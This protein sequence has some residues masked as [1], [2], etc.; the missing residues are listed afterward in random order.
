MIPFHK[1]DKLPLQ[2]WPSPKDSPGYR[3]TKGDPQVSGR[4]DVGAQNSRHRLG[5]WACTEG[6][7]ECTESGNELQTL[8]EGRLKVTKEDGS[9]V[10]Y[11]PGDSFYTEKGEKVIWEIIEPVRKVFFNFNVAGHSDNE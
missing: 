10:E 11:G 8:F 9:F 5:I 4:L 7:F 1:N 3:V 6:A 2:P